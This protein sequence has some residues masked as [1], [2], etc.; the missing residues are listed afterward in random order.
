MKKVNIY[1]DGWWC[2]RIGGKDVIE[3]YAA[4]TVLEVDSNDAVAICP[5]NEEVI[6]QILASPHAALYPGLQ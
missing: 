4:G 5:P 2:H 6:S 1:E 3:W